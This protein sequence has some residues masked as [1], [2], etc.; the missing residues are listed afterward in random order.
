[1]DKKNN[2]VEVILHVEYRE[3]QVVK[4]V[5]R[6]NFFAKWNSRMKISDQ[7]DQRRRKYRLLQDNV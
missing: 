4:I 2:F 3:H 7:R 1:M 5:H 6:L